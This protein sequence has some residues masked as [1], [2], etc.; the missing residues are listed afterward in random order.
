MTA[1]TTTD[2]IWQGPVTPPLPTLAVVRVLSCEGCQLPII[3][4]KTGPAPR[5]CPACR[6]DRNR[7]SAAKRKGASSRGASPRN[8]IRA[9]DVRADVHLAR[10]VTALRMANRQ[11]HGMLRDA[12]SGP[13]TARAI[14]LGI[15]NAMEALDAAPTGR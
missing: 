14:L 15:A 3:R 6:A 11:A 4:S 2:Q 12:L 13:A 8:T 1:C 5:W 10:R 7:T 9:G